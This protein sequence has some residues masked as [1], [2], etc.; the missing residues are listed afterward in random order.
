MDCLASQV[1]DVFN[2]NRSDSEPNKK[3]FRR[4]LDLHDYGKQRNLAHSA[5]KHIDPYNFLLL[6]VN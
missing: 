6:Y 1:E 2:S 3:D 5:G 4:R